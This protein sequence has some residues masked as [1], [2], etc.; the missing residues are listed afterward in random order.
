MEYSSFVAVSEKLEVRLD[1]RCLEKD[2]WSRQGFKAAQLQFVSVKE[3]TLKG[4]YTIPGDT[5]D[6]T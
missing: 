1:K 5:L 3:V 4:Y 2:L 6:N